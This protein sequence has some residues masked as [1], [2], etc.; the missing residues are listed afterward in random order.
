MKISIPIQSPPS[1]ALLHGG[2][3]E[4]GFFHPV[5][6]LDHLF[7]MV[8]VGLVSVL[9]KKSAIFTTPF[10][11]VLFMSLGSYFGL[12]NIHFLNTEL[13][14]SLSV[15]ILGFS[16]LLKKYI[17]FKLVLIFVAF[18]GFFHGHAHGVEMPKLVYANNYIF[19]FLSASIILHIIGIFIGK[20]SQKFNPKILSILALII[21]SIGLYFLFK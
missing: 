18:F 21:I 10:T 11:F 16:I 4:A 3:F 14:I 7:A 12:K 20:I 8:A 6:G 5:L 9:Y 17:P 15:I 1:H 2:G 19:G 13:A